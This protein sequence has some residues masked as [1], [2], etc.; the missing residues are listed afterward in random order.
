VSPR[1]YVMESYRRTAQVWASHEPSR[2]VGL[3]LLAAFDE[4]A[5]ALGGAL[6]L[7]YLRTDRFAAATELELGYLWA[8]I[9]APF[10]VRLFDQTWIYAGPRLANW[11]LDPLFG[12]PI[13][14]S[15]RVYDGL[16]LRA[17]WQPSWQGFKYYN[18][19]S[20]FGFAVAYQF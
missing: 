13:G 14:A 19:R 3:T 11:G 4:E 20:H 5:L 10:S 18:R 17:E 7:R 9:S 8:A 16:M 15:V 12:V 6:R 2:V 1:P